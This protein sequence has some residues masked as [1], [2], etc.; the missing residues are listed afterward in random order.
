MICY[1]RS[2]WIDEIIIGKH[3]MFKPINLSCMGIHLG[4][5]GNKTKI[6]LIY[7]KCEPDVSMCICFFVYIYLYVFMGI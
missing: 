2:I 1:S 3:L 4:V 6:V 7:N 5:L